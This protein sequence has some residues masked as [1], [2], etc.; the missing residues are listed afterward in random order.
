LLNRLPPKFSI[1]KVDGLRCNEAALGLQPVT[2]KEF[3]T[4]L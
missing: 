3:A 2:S 1:A 4:A